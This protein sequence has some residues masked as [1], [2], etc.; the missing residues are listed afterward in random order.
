M[1][2][3]ALAWIGTIGFISL[4]AATQELWLEIHRRRYGLWRSTRQRHFM[5]SQDERR[6]M[7]HALTR[8]GPDRGLELS[9]RAF[10]TI[11]V[12]AF[13]GSVALLPIRT[14]P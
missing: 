1:S 3:S 11:A 10:I 8:R 4:M 12:L 5:A 7:W 14:S 2:P 13:L 9:R 6:L